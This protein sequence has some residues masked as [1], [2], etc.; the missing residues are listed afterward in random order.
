M[1]RVLESPQRPPPSRAP[2]ADAALE[3]CGLALTAVDVELRLASPSVGLLLGQATSGDDHAPRCCHGRP[4]PHRALRIMFPSCRVSLAPEI[5]AVDKPLP[6]SRMRVRRD[7]IAWRARFAG[8]VRPSSRRDAS[9]L[10]HRRMYASTAAAISRSRQRPD[11]CG[12]DRRLRER[13]ARPRGPLALPSGQDAPCF[14]RSCPARQAASANS[15]P[16]RTPPMRRDPT[17]DP[18]LVRGTPRNASSASS[19]ACAAAL[20]CSQCQ[21]QMARNRR[22]SRGTYARARRAMIRLAAAALPF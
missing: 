18:V 20:C 3:R 17:S 12:Y 21:I 1:L 9:A 22:E 8:T 16:A 5:C 10:R 14:L 13:G 6:I 19:I 15:G 7:R 2:L 11:A 4:R